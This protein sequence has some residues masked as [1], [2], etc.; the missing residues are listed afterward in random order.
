MDRVWTM[1]L[2]SAGASL[3]AP[4]SAVVAAEQWEPMLLAAVIVVR[5]DFSRLNE[6]LKTL[7]SGLIR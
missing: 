4:L 1:F 2:I 7:G 3:F 5:F 6:S